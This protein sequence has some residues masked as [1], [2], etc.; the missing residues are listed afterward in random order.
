MTLGA[1]NASGAP[2]NFIS[3]NLVTKTVIFGP[4]V[5]LAAGATTPYSFTTDVSSGNRTVSGSL[6]GFVGAGTYSAL[7]TAVLGNGG[8]VASPTG[9]L[10]APITTSASPTIQLTYNFTTS[11]TTPEPASLA[12]F[13]VGLAGLGVVRR[14]RKA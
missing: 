3:P 10:S 14:R 2:S 11:T 8:F 7:V 4:Q 12:L 1:Q 6:S 9:Q 5:T 13:G